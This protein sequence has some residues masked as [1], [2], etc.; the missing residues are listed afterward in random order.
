MSTFRQVCR[1]SLTAL[2]LSIPAPGQLNEASLTIRLPQPVSQFHAGEAIPIELLFSSTIPNTFSM[3]T[4]SYDR[5]GR[6]DLEQFHVTPEGRDPLHNY[7]QL[8]TFMGGGLGSSLT[9]TSEPHVLHEDLNEWVSLDHPGHYTLY[10]TT[11]R[12]SRQGSPGNEPME[13]RSN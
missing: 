9:L 13:L 11:G 6:L 5:S 1:I 4:R 7:Y 10:V 2:A 3:S 12:I 8:G